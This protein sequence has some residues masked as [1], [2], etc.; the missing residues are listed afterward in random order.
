MI[1][2]NPI[3]TVDEL[4]ILIGVG[5]PTSQITIL[6]KPGCPDCV[7]CKQTMESIWNLDA[8][9]LD[10]GVFY[11]TEE[12]KLMFRE[13]MRKYVQE[14]LSFPFVFVNNM[15]IGGYSALIEYVTKIA[16]DDW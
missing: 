14:P 12:T 6:G 3:G 7:K 4:D 8:T 15:Y 2:T 13:K 16:D 5:P 10:C 11:E 9:Y 1:Q